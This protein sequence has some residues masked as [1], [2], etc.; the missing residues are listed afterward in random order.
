ME[1]PLHLASGMNTMRLLD[2]LPPV[3]RHAR[4]KAL[5]EQI[6]TAS[7]EGVCCRVEHRVAQLSPAEARGYIRVR[8]APVIVQAVDT[9]L[10]QASTRLAAQ[11]ERLIAM[12][13]EEVI[14][15]VQQRI[16]DRQARVAP[17]RRAA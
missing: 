11:R 2:V 15:R 1:G 14:G 9:L 17:L 3:R 12:S 16:R 8:S 4:L 10:V 7:V 5:A 13:R 6:A